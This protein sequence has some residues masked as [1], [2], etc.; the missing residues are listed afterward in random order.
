MTWPSLWKMLRKC[1]T[2]LASIFAAVG[3]PIRRRPALS[4]LCFARLPTIWMSEHSGLAAADA[5]GTD[6]AAVG[7]DAATVAQPSFAVDDILLASVDLARAALIET[8][9]VESVGPVT[10]H[11]AEGERVLSFLFASDVAG[12]PG[13]FWRVTL[14]R[15]DDAPPTVSESQLVPGET[16]LLAPKW[17]P[18][19]ERLAEYRAS[20]LAA[21]NADVVLNEDEFPDDESSDDLDAD[22]DDF[23]IEEIDIDEIEPDTLSDDDFLGIDIDSLDADGDGD[24]DGAGVRRWVH[25]VITLVSVGWWVVCLESRVQGRAQHVVVFMFTESR[26][27]FLWVY[28]TV[29]CR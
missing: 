3:T 12:Y 7:S 27:A 16:A 18:W 23:G 5:Q 6:P 20:Q 26:V 9:P 8:V 29:M 14:T 19:S 1:L 13:W 21:E 11:T 15:V 17:I 10:A 24:G 22:G 25:S 2:V 28:M 4:R